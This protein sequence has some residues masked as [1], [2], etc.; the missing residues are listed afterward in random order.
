LYGAAN[1]PVKFHIYVCQMKIANYCPDEVNILSAGAN[2]AATQGDHTAATAFYQALAKPLIFNPIL[3]QS[4]SHSKD[5]KVIKHDIFQ[6]NPKQST[7]SDTQVHV[8]TANYYFRWNKECRYDWQDT[9]TVGADITNPDTQLDQGYNSTTVRPT[10]RIYLIV[11]AEDYSTSMIDA[12]DKGT[13]A[14]YDIM[15]KN[16]YSRLR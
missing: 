16:T 4:S 11:A 5:M 12:Y 14:S 13:N 10:E 2:A 9:A 15:V 1:L 3:V 6:M 8:K 7:D